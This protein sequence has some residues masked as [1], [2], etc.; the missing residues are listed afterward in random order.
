M[1]AG[2]GTLFLDEVDSLSMKAQITLLSFLQDGSF[3]P[4][5]AKAFA[6]SHARIVAATNADIDGLVHS[7]A[8][9][10]N[11]LYRL[12]IVPVF[13]PPLRERAGDVRLL[14]DNF[15]R[16]LARQNGGG[17]RRIDEASLRRL[18]ACAW[19]R[20]VRELANVL[21]RLFLLADGASLTLAA[22]ALGAPEGA[23]E[24]AS[25]GA[26]VMVEPFQLARAQALA[27]LV[28]NPSRHTGCC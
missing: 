24:A 5:G 2:N 12:S 22:D 1:Q 28:R 15:L 11:L 9:R 14:V 3:R 16:V 10:S 21:Q 19:P 25:M 27:E 6:I 18:E 8:L 20:N 17:P 23:A 26:V 13:M 4:L 7:G